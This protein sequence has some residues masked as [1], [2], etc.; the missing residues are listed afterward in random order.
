MSLSRFLRD[1]L[2]IPLGGNRKGKLRRHVNLLIT[3]LLGGL[4]HGANW[5]FLV[6]GGLHGMYL[7]INHA[8]QG[9]RGRFGFESSGAST[10]YRAFSAGITFLAVVVAWVFFRSD[11]VGTGLSI[12]KG[13]TGYNGLALPMKWVDGPEHGFFIQWLLDRGIKTTENYALFAAGE[14][15]RLLALLLLICWCLPNTV[16]IFALDRRAVKPFWRWKPNGWWAF[17]TVIMA[18]FS[19]LSISNPSEFIYFQF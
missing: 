11:S 7:V 5:T 9:L 17:L 18:F 8:W 16:D 2:Y 3:M 10:A 15:L 19:V 14:E 13:M 4:W 12:I 6:W 1:Y